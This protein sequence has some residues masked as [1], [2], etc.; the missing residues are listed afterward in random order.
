AR[1]LVAAPD[2]DGN[3]YEAGVTFRFGQ[4]VLDGYAYESNERL[5]GGSE[6]T[7]RGM[8]WSFSTRF[9]GAL[10]IVTGTKRRGVVR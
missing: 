1:N 6:R 10:P 4:L 8:I 2:I 7:H 9:A 5:D 3:R